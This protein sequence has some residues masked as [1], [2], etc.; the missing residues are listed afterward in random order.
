[1]LSHVNNLSY[2]KRIFFNFGCRVISPSYNQYALRTILTLSHPFKNNFIGI[3]F[4]LKICL[5][6]EMVCGVGEWSEVKLDE[7]QGFLQ[8]LFE[9]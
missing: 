6:V 5:F 9:L 1:M 7:F 4:S 8:L 3:I 2:L